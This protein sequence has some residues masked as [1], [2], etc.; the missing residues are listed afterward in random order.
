MRLKYA[1]KYQPQT[2]IVSIGM[3][4]S[5]LQFPDTQHDIAGTPATVNAEAPPNLTH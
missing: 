2:I 1:I 4:E 5:P 3:T